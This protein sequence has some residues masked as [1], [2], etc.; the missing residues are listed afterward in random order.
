MVVVHVVLDCS[1]PFNLSL[2]KTACTVQ[3]HKRALGSLTIDGRCARGS[4]GVEEGVE[5]KEAGVGGHH[6]DERPVPNPSGCFLAHDFR[7]DS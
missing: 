3:A 6:R 7:N 4:V 5:E 1:C 2:K